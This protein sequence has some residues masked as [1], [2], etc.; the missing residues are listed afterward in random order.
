MPILILLIGI[1]AVHLW[2]VVFGALLSVLHSVIAR[3]KSQGAPEPFDIL[4]CWMVLGCG[5]LGL[6]LWVQ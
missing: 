4:M 5:F 2:I 1:S 6:I 3:R